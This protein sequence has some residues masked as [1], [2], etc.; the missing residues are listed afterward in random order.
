MR[1]Q[2]AGQGGVVTDRY[3]ERQ[4]G[5]ATGPRSTKRTSSEADMPKLCLKCGNYDATADITPTSRCPSCGVVYAKLSPPPSARESMPAAI[6]G[7]SRWHPPR[8]AHV[9]LGLAAVALLFIL[10]VVDADGFIPVLDHANLAFHE[11]GH[12][13]FGILGSTLGLYGGT[14]GQLVFPVAAA[15]TCW[16][17][18]EAVGFALSGVWLFENLLNIARYMADARAQLLPLVGGGE[19]DWYH[20]FSGWSVLHA[21]TGIAA[22]TRALG[23]LGMVG[24]MLWLWRQRCSQRPPT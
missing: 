5:S 7:P 16:R 21:D 24:C 17:R 14:L 1:A 11:A 22:F 13:I 18:R 4:V 2:R 6:E 20:I 12:L 3:A 23:W 19:H 15:V 10:I 9:W 8:E